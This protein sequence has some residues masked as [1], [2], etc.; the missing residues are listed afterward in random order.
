ME[1]LLTWSGWGCTV[2]STVIAIVQMRKK[3][4]HKKEVRKVKAEM[5][6]VVLKAKEKGVAININNGDITIN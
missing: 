6:K 5:K 1:D 3:N 2:I 4:E